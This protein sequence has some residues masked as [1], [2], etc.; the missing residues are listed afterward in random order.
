MDI[1]IKGDI[2]GIETATRI[3]ERFHIPVVFLTAN[4]D[5]A[6]VERAKKTGPLAYLLK[7]FEDR[8]IRT[9]MEIALHR[10]KLEFELR[11]NAQALRDSEKR[12][13]DLFEHSNHAVIIHDLAG[14]ILDVNE[15]TCELLGY[16]KDRLLPLEVTSFRPNGWQP[17][18]DNP[19]Q[20]VREKGRHSF[21]SRFE[22]ADGEVLDIDISARI[23]DREKGIVQGIIRDITERKRVEQ[24][25]EESETKS[26]EILNNTPIHLWAFDGEH[27]S[28]LSRAWYI[29]SGQDPTLPLTVDRWTEIVHPDDLEEAVKLWMEH[30]ETKTKHDNYFRLRRKDGKYRDFFC[31]AIPVFD[32]KG[33]FK[34]FQGYNIDITERKQAE[35][36]LKRHRDHLDELIKRADFRTVKSE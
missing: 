26:R 11:Q 22:R 25:L 21:E 24:A 1:Q 16:K 13:R 7:P 20:I 27:Y 34:Y 19:L 6:T 35:A 30:W 8:D 32:D 28:Y 14:R 29:Y 36:E 5:I 3:Q 33:N 17:P 18:D 10:H 9:T 23:V 2:D 12:Y 31:H 4:S 15:R